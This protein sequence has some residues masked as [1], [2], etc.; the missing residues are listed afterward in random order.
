VNDGI[1]RTTERLDILEHS[2]PELA[3]DDRVSRRAG[4]ARS[5]SQIAR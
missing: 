4:I 5:H 2:N 3:S 1:E